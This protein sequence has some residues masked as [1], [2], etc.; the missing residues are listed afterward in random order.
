M[1]LD[2]PARMLR[3]LSLLQSRRAWPG[4]ELADRLGVTGRTVRRDVERLRELGYPVEGTTGVAG[5]YRLASGATLPPL[6]LDD[7][8][9]VAIAAALLTAAS[10]AVTGVERSSA[11]A[12]AKLEQVLPARLRHRVSALG[13]T[14][15]AAPGD[16]RGRVDPEVL[17]VLAAACRDHEVVTC[18]TREADDAELRVEPHHL[19]TGHHRW[20]LVGYDLDRAEWRSFLLD[21]LTGPVPTGRGFEPRELPAPS[22]AAYVSRSLAD[23][24]HRYTVEATVQAPAESVHAVLRG[25]LPGSVRQLDDGSCAVRLTA[26]TIEDITL[27]VLAMSTAA[28]PLTVEGPDELRKHL[29][30]IAGNLARAVAD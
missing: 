8:E 27:D 9:A 13:G 7:E 22:P 12:L 3:L 23:A 17:A 24:P 19:L 18:R 30:E 5:G 29:A 28:V 10:G 15:A 20:Y 2:L 4:A 11:Q 1:S 6:L 25:P 14:S 16:G 26:D 21:R